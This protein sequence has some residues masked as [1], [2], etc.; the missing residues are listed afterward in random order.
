[1]AILSIDGNAKTVKGQSKGFLTGIVYL[2]PHDIAHKVQGKKGTVCPSA[3]TAGCYNACLYS[4]GRGRFSNVQQARINRAMLFLSDKNAFMLQLHTEIRKLIKK[5]HK[6]G[7][8]PIVRLNGTS[9]VDYTAIY[10]TSPETQ[11]HGNVF[12]HFPEIKFYD[13]TKNVKLYR[14]K[15]LPSNYSL[16]LSYSE[17][18]PEYAALSRTVSRETGYPL[19]IVVRDKDTKRNALA[20]IPGAVDGDETDLRPLDPAGTRVVLLTAKGD[21]KKD[22]SGFVVDSLESFA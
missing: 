21:G 1:M 7:L 10:Y 2:A 3:I 20:T 11:L 9:D 19:A 8:I 12:Q 5:A 22:T 6:K 14:Q 18:S 17:A 16:T 15:V 13:Y 4:A